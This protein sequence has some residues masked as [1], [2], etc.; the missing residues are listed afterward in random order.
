MGK[1]KWKAQF[2][3]PKRRPGRAPL[4]I[5]DLKPGRYKQQK[6]NAARF[7]QQIQKWGKIEGHRRHEKWI[8]QKAAHNAQAKAKKEG[9]ANIKDAIRFPK[10]KAPARTLQRH[11]RR[12][13]A[14]SDRAK[15]RYMG[16]DAPATTVAIGCRRQEKRCSKHSMVTCGPVIQCRCRHE[17][18]RTRAHKKAETEKL[19]EGMWIC[20]ADPSAPSSVRSAIRSP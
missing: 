9:N 15:C 13:P 8:K 17:N 18:T 7:T 1:I 2:M 3:G 4:P 10:E 12:F 6:E 11:L 5:E 14:A 20:V 19:R 16:C